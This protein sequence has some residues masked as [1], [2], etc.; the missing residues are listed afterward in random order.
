MKKSII[1]FF[2]VV[3]VFQSLFATTCP[4]AEIIPAQPTF[5]YTQSVT[6]GSTNDLTSANSPVCAPA[7]ASYLGGLEAVYV[8][9]PTMNYINANINYTGQTWS[10]IFVYA[11]CP[12]TGGVC[13]GGVSSSASNKN[14]AVSQFNAGTTYYIV[15]DTWPTPASPC[16]GTFTID[17]QPGPPNNPPAPVQD[18]GSP[19]C[20]SGTNLTVS[21]TPDTDVIWYWQTT[22]LGTS[23][24]TPYDGPFS[25]FANGTYYLRAYNTVT[26]LWSTGSSSVTVNNFPTEELPPAPIAA[27]NPACLPGTEVTMPN[28]PADVEYFWQTVINGSSTTS[29][30]TTPL[31]VSE[32]SSVLVAAYNSVTQCWSNTNSTSVT[33]QTNIPPAPTANPTVFNNCSGTLS[34]PISVVPGLIPGGLCSTTASA[35]G[36]DN[37]NVTATVTNFSC[38]GGAPI[39][40]ATLDATIGGFCPSWY[41]YSIIVNG[42]VVATQQCNQTGFNL[43]PYLPLTSVS[44]V[45]FDNDNFGDFVTL[46]L[47]VNIQY[48]IGTYDVVWYSDEIGGDLLGSDETLETV[49]TS[50]MPTAEPGLYTFWAGSLSGACESANRVSVTLNIVNVDAEIEAINNTC[51]GASTG[52][53]ALTSVNCGVEPFTYSL[54]FGPFSGI[55][56]NLSPGSYSVVIQDATGEQSGPLTLVITQPDPVANVSTSVIS[57]T[58]IELSWTNSGSETAWNIE[59]GPV[60]FTPGTG[61]LVEVSNNPSIVTGLS[62]NS[63]YHFYV[64]SVCAPGS[65]GSFTGP[66]S[67]STPQ[68]QVSIFP[69]IEDFENGGVEWSILNGNNINQWVVGSAVSESGTQSLYVS[70][71]AGANNTYNITSISLSQAY[72]DIAFPATDGEIQLTFNWRNI[73]ENNWDYI[74]AWLVPIDFIPGSGN[75]LANQITPNLTGSPLTQRINLTG[76]LQGQGNWQTWQGLIPAIYEGNSARLVFQWRNDGSIGTQPPG[77]IDNV[78]IIVGECPRPNAITVTEISQNSALVSWTPGTPGDDLWVIEYGPQGFTLGTGTEVTVDTNPFLLEG[79]DNS[80]FYSLS[81]RTV[82]DDQDST[83]SIFSTL[84][85]FQTQFGCGGTFV[86]DGGPNGN[87]LPNQNKVYVICPDDAGDYIEINFDSFNTQVQSDGFYIYYGDEINI[88]NIIPSGNPVGFAPLLAPNAW[89]GTQLTGMMFESQGAGECLTFNFLSNGFTELSGWEAPISCYPCIPTPGVDG[90]LAVCRLD[91]SV[92]LNEVV[93]LNSDRGFWIFPG[94]QGLIFNESMLNISLL[95]EGIFDVYYIVNTPCTSDTT[96]ATIHI[97]PP[98]SAGNSATLTNCNNG[99]VNLYDGL[100]GTIDLGGQWF[101]PAGLELNSALIQVDGEIDGVYNYYYV[102][103]NGVCPADTS[104]AEVTLINCVGL[105]ENEIAGFELYPNPTADV[106]FLSYSGD[107]LNATVYLVDAKGSVISV[108]ERMFETNSTLEIKMTDLQAGVYFVT[109]VSETGKNI[110]QVVKQ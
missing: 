66:I 33:I 12:T 107:N 75:S 100:T 42:N 85:N 47:T 106:V 1:L 97:Y 28:P 93:T 62:P 5:P 24:S 13:V 36:T 90:E 8:W 26:M 18:L 86:D 58:E 96:V 69:W 35:S 78:N 72:R 46:N 67:A 81:I 82:C 49:G 20:T 70:Q 63:N 32:S 89:W 105:T 45:S 30:A 11:G 17:A 59:Y 51:N 80:T 87:Y 15:F 43:T 92:D 29:P 44:I 91:G 94:N 95:P 74:Q 14:L 65:L 22:S 23:Q 61:T 98:S 48:A 54:D 103:S 37:S 68:N 50:I 56:T 101:S 21:G 88:D 83:Y 4:N 38:T 19:T 64:Q 34:A 41:V 25:I 31:F 57:S 73:G 10:A 27:E 60:G 71:D 110:I 39:L 52:S 9:T 40:G 7:T 109:I 6:C 55:P 84:V 77:A 2:S 53:F 76:N 3:L 79:L 16:P 108:E 104:Y 102:T 99:F